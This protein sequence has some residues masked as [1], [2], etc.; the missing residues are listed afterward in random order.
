M[1]AKLEMISTKNC[2]VTI[3]YL[4]K[5]IHSLYDPVVEAERMILPLLSNRKSVV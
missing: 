1:P 5:L 4:G 2:L 3:R